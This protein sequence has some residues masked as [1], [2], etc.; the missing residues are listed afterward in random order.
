MYTKCI[1]CMKTAVELVQAALVDQNLKRFPM[2]VNIYYYNSS[3]CS[4]T[5]SARKGTIKL[6]LSH[7]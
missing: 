5:T 7:A 6:F 1:P 3:I 2:R 4:Y